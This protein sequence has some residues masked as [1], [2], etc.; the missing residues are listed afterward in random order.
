MSPTV[1]TPSKAPL[2][3]ADPEAF[4]AGQPVAVVRP[5]L[6]DMP[7]LHRL[8]QEA[9]R[10]DFQYFPQ[11]YIAEIGRQNNLWRLTIALTRANRIMAVAKVRGRIV[12]YIIG[13]L[14]SGGTSELYW[15]YVDRQ[16]RNH[17]VGGRLLQEALQIARSKGAHRVF[18]VTYNLRD[19]YQ[20]QGFHYWGKQT[21]QGVSL[22]A[23][24]YKLHD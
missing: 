15:L 2:Q 9:L 8:F 19:Y 24:E 18:L 20:R 22:D 6:W 11:E 10:R 14:T 1:K 13:S 5:T 21:I 4:G 23:M 3:P 12:G 7:T 16:Y 17:R